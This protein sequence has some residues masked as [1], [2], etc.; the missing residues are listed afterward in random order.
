MT[1][2]ETAHKLAIDH[3]DWALK[4]IRPLLISYMEHGFKHGVEYALSLKE[5]NNSDKFLDACREVIKNMDE[6]TAPQ[7]HDIEEFY[8]E[9]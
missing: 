9:D 1:Q 2:N 8:K 5:K 4:L 6:R 7:V 3:V